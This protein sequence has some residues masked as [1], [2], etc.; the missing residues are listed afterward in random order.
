[1]RIWHSHLG[2]GMCNVG[3][4]WLVLGAKNLMQEYLDPKEISESSDFWVKRQFDH[5]NQNYDLLFIGGGG[6]LGE[7]TPLWSMK[8]HEWLKQI[9]IPFIVYGVGLNFFR[10]QESCYN[11]N[12]RKKC[13]E[14]LEKIKEQSI[15][16]RVRNDGSKEKLE[17]YGLKC[18]ETPDPG[19][20]VEKDK[21]SPKK[22]KYV[23]INIAG[24]SLR[25]RY[26]GNGIEVQPFCTR[27]NKIVFYLLDKGY[28]I[29]LSQLI[30]QDAICFNYL[31]WERDLWKSW[32]PN[33]VKLLDFN[34][35][36]KEGLS[37]YKGAKFTIGMRGHAQIIPIGLKVPTISISTQDKNRELMRKLDL[38][39]WNIEVNDPLLEEKIKSLIDEIERDPEALRIKY[40]KKLKEMKDQTKE[41]FKIIKERLDSSG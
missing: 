12:C 10:L 4:K 37:Y 39:K 26:D 6:W 3:D 41:E 30:P 34:T 32:N 8:E 33:R 2:Y 19:F 40:S 25:E 18:E 1:L 22:G 7:E 16:F 27:I 38:E 20:W 15:L 13:I 35:M 11:P 17:S 23:I 14:N 36:H 9:K 5:L 21:I 28:T 29:Y 24:A 31:T